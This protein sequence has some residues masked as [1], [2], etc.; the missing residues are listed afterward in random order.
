MHKSSENGK[1]SY[2]IPVAATYRTAGSATGVGVDMAKY[3]NYVA[4]INVAGATQWQGALTC[5]IA[6]STDNSTFSTAYLATLTIATATTNTAQSLELRAEQMSDGYR[7]LRVE[8]APASG[9]GNLYSAINL[10]FN[11]RY[12]AP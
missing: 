3:N 12:A 9:T 2:A 8:V 10:Q 7:Y 6:E 11:P 5:S 4:I 1:L